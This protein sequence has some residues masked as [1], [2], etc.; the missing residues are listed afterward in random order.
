MK[1]R[2]ELC[3]DRFVYPA[4]NEVAL[5]G[6]PVGATTRPPPLSS[7][8]TSK[9]TPVAA[10]EEALPSMPWF[11]AFIGARAAAICSLPASISLSF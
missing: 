7:Y 6:S 5:F 1:W 11:P 8:T 2:E 9:F 4:F 3:D 10:F